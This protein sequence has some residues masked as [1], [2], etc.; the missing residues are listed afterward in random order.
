VVAVLV[1][2]VRRGSANPL[3]HQSEQLGDY[4]YQA[5]TSAGVATLYLT[6]RERKIVRRAVGKLGV[7]TVELEGTMPDQPSDCY[8]GTGLDDGI[9]LP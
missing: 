2:M 9:V 4:G 1:N 7:G 5:G 3:G 6:S 8:Y